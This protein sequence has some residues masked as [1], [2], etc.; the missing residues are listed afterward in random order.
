MMSAKIAIPGL[1]KVTVFWNKVY[2][3]IIPVDDVTNQFWS[4][5]ANYIADVFLSPKFD[6]SSTSMREFITT[7]TW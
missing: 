2:D 7:S 1:P 6:N 5:D 3:V 4:R